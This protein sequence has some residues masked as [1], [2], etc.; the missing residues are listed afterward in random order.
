MQLEGGQ[1]MTYTIVLIAIFLL[2]IDV[3]GA[4]QYSSQTTAPY[5]GPRS[6]PSYQSQTT[7]RYTGPATSPYQSQ[8]TPHYTGP[9]TSPY[10][11]ETTP[12]YTGPRHYRGPDVGIPP[13]LI[14]FVHPYRDAPTG[15]TIFIP[16]EDR[17][18]RYEPQD[19]LITSPPAR[20]VPWLDD[21]PPITAPSIMVEE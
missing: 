2:L 15:Q 16:S 14:P 4:G 20:A 12:A 11:S 19:I 5:I 6:G 10:R 18:Y 17:Y 1:V 21:V 3:A 7:P 8:T 13:A 9:R